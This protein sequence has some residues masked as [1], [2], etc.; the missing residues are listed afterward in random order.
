MNEGVPRESPGFG[1][2]APSI[3]PAKAGWMQL[4]AVVPEV[5]PPQSRSTMKNGDENVPIFR[6]W[7]WKDQRQEPGRY[8]LIPEVLP[9]QTNL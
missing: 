5:W 3:H 4:G 8:L 1:H 2:P 7:R 6:H 9:L